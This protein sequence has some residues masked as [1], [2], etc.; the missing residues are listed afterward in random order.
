MP[1]VLVAINV[2]FQIK[3]L[4]W[5][6]ELKFNESTSNKGSNIILIFSSFHRQAKIKIYNSRALDY[7]KNDHL[8]HLYGK[9]YTKRTLH[10][11]EQD[12]ADSYRRAERQLVCPAIHH[13]GPH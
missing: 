10:R 5:R 8:E 6:V 11:N 1:D 4:K 12:G 7:C 9:N 13:F 2:A 3:M